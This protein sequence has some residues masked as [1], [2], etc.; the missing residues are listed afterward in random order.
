VVD[1]RY[2]VAN[3]YHEVVRGR[4]GVEI[5]L[6]LDSSIQP[7][8]FLST[9]GARYPITEPGEILDC[10]EIS[11]VG[12]SRGYQ[13]SLQIQPGGRAW[14]HPIET[15]SRSPT[16]MRRQ[17]QGICLLIWWPVELWGLERKRLDLSL[18]IEV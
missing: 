13:V 9:H 14:Y 7:A 6:N 18:S 15:V 5:N 1:V 3:R 4:F 8:T 17:F 10:E 11:F 16:G 2:E 12:A